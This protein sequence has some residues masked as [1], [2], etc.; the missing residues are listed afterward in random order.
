[1]LPGPSPTP[2]P[3]MTFTPSLSASGERPPLA[4]TT[5]TAK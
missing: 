4:F 1:M 2:P 5:R 3:A